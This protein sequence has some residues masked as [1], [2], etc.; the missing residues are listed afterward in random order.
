[1][2]T[3]LTAAQQD[4]AIYLP[5][6]S[7]VYSSHIGRQQKAAYVDQ[8]RMPQGIPDMEMLNFFNPSKGLFEYRW[9][10]YSAGHA[11]LDLD[12]DVPSEY[13]IRNRGKH[14]LLLADSGGYQI[15]SGVWEADW[16][17]MDARAQ[18][19]RAT[20]FK[21]LSQISDYSMVLDIPT[22]LVNNPDSVKKTNIHTVEDAIAATCANHEYF[23]ENSFT[24]T[25]FLNVLQGN[26]HESSDTWYEVM[27]HYND[28]RKH[29]KFFRGWSLA[30]ANAADPHL[31]LK[32]IVTIIH[33]GLLEEGKHDWMHFLGNSKLEWAVL[34]T[35][36]QRAVRKYH[37][38]R[39]T[40]S[41][42]SA[43]PFL[44]ASKGQNYT[45][46]NI[47][48]RGRWSHKNGPATD[49][50]AYATDTRRYRD[51]ILQDGINS[52]FYDSPVSDRLTAKDICVYA[53]GDLNKLGKEGKTSW[54]TF[55]YILL[56]GHNIWH[57]INAIQEANRAFDA[58]KIPGN[59]LNIHDYTSS[60]DIVNRVFA[61][62]DYDNR[63]AIL[64]EYSDFWTNIPGS[65]G[66]GGKKAVNADAFFNK[67]FSTVSPS[68]D[69]DDDIGEIEIENLE[70]IL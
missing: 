27:K 57:Y 39:F 40:I 62:P 37:N 48:H 55:S 64:D 29:D 5:A 56:M 65:R 18:K 34:L 53:P 67:H 59:L 1:M 26:N 14:T 32:R 21:W 31:A 7:S 28:P 68:V 19:Y 33:D 8:T 46:Y 35:D 22:W 10:L 60:R 43:G 20:V 11:N 25:K 4:Y 52:V 58:G 30:G 66:L 47:E 6:I 23:M 36:I 51:V 45:H 9:G 3:N 16:K 42:D 2:N 70:E 15:A 50:K 12:K 13:M 61:E 41:F 49:N 38:P 24:D 69:V 44:A 63:L 54:D 17:N